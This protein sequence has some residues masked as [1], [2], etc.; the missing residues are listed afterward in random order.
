MS[1]AAVN[2]SLPIASRRGRN[3]RFAGIALV[4]AAAVI[5]LVALSMRQTKVYY[6]TVGELQAKGASAYGQSVRV[7]GTVQKGSIRHLGDGSIKF[8]AVDKTGRMLVT[9][10]GVV[11]DIFGK[12]NV[13]VV[14]EGSERSNGVFEANT[15][16][17]KCPSKFQSSGNSRSA[18][19]P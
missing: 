7:A 17:A 5:L 16:L 2:S 14:V 11:P 6:M 3:F 8:V 4:I 1:Q 15:L 19:S 10:N 9:Y 12:P 18:S 13:Q